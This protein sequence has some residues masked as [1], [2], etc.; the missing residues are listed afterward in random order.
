MH[1]QNLQVCSPTPVNSLTCRHHQL[2]ILLTFLLVSNLPS[3]GVHLALWFWSS[4]GVSWCSISAWVM[5]MTRNLPCIVL[6]LLVN[7][8]ALLHQ[9]ASSSIWVKLACQP[10][11]VDRALCVLHPYYW[12]VWVLKAL[13]TTVRKAPVSAV[14]TSRLV[15]VTNVPNFSWKINIYLFLLTV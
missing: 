3:L 12:K 5:K 14:L 1:Y 4:G 11:E 7:G 15:D 2:D 13:H 9:A 10:S 6:S 8:G